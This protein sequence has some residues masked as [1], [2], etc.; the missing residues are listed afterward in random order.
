[1][2]TI[3][4]GRSRAD[5]ADYVRALYDAGHTGTAIAEMLGVRHSWVYELLNDPDARAV[6]A[7]K[8]RNG[9]TCQDCGARTDGSNG[10]ANAPTRCVACTRAKATAE[11]YWTPER[12]IASIQE[13]ARIHGEPPKAHEW[14]RA[15]EKVD[16]RS[17]WPSVTL[18][19]REFGSW[20]N[21]LEAA[22]FIRRPKHM[23]TDEWKAWRAQQGNAA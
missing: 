19:Q 3:L 12:I 9:G 1:L 7:R 20:S 11:R 14:L 13:W 21:A 17:R 18:A 16:G 6:K 10:R 8:A 2:S 15:Q 23:L 4:G 5:Q 22:G